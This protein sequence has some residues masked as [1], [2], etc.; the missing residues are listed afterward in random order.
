V[1][2]L[3][4][5]VQSAGSAPQDR[6][7]TPVIVARHMSP[8]ARKLLR[9]ARL[10]W[11]DEH[12]DAWI[13]APPALVIS[14]GQNPTAASALTRS[15]G[16]VVGAF[17][18]SAG[19]SAVA[20]AILAGAAGEH[21]TIHDVSVDPGL[22]AFRIPGIRALEARSG[23][24]HAHVSRSLAQFDDVG[25]TIKTGGRR[26]KTAGRLLVQ[27]SQMLSSW[28][29][30]HSLQ[31]IPTL[32]T[33]ALFRSARAF[34]HDTLTRVLPAHQWCLTG[35]LAADLLAPLATEVPT[36][37]CYVTPD[38]YDRLP[39][40]LQG[41]ELVRVEIGAR[42]L[43][44]PAADAVL[45]Q[46]VPTAVGLSASPIRVY[47]D[48]LDAGVRGEDAAQHLRETLIGF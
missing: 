31:Q 46:A 47:A 21:L 18:W 11:A 41:T 8:G 23:V 40:T 35:W 20:E 45:R 3:I 4:A 17:K 6:A 26:G 7:R 27:A 16:T 39:Q 5:A 30:H 22:Q 44:H 48:L 38:V 43:F 28:A 29:R 37:S 33:H 36:V 12:G 15:A 9:Q 24:S 34:A 14:V 42:V 10:S 25:W 19:T 13:Q 1:G 2:P 32:R